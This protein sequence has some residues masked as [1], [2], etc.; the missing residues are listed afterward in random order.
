M[1][2]QN[3]L[4]LASTAALIANASAVVTIDYIT[5]A[6]PN[7]A[8]DTTGYGS[9]AYNYEIGKYEVTNA[10]YAAFLN[11]VDPTGSNTNGIYNTSMGTH[12]TGGIA[13]NSG[14]SAGAKY[15]IRS[16]FGD[17]TNRPVNFVSWYDAARFSNWMHNGQGAG[18]TETGAYTL[19]G[20]TGIVTKNV[21]ATIYIPSE[22]EWYKAAYYNGTNSSYSPYANGQS[23]ITTAD[24]N[25]GWAIEQVTVVGSY[26]NDPSSYGTFDQGGNVS[27][28]NDAVISGTL[29]GVRGGSFGSGFYDN[30][31]PLLSS[32][33]SSAS[34][35]IENESTG[36]RVASVPEP[37]AMVLTVLASGMMLIRRKR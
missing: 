20:N 8:A 10:Q 2:I 5:V 14:A 22:N 9:V 11:A 36:F 30:S 4:T 32:A 34:P 26:T 6:N 7:N 3:L 16:N 17:M 35:T 13:L 27:E 25:Y 21:G 33:R 28:W 12:Y 31:S 37:S 29:R 1:K 15:T 19:S 23:S 24:A 18:S